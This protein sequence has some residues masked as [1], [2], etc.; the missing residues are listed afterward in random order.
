MG[1]SG[2]RHA[3]GS[4]RTRHTSSSSCRRHQY[5]FLRHEKSRTCPLV[6]RFY[7]RRSRHLWFDETPP[8]PPTTHD[9][10]LSPAPRFRETPQ[11][12]FHLCRSVRA[13]V[14]YNPRLLFQPQRLQARHSDGG[15]QVS[16][17]CC[18]RPWH[19]NGRN[20]KST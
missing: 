5:R 10:I 7:R 15:V 14:H 19:V 1:L 8:P 12:Q 13:L 2:T 3:V 20:G 11:L 9:E 16:C 4:S 17:V 6:M 18:L